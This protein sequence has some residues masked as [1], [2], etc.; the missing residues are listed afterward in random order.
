MA[1]ITL[2]ALLLVCACTSTSTVGGMRA[3][4]ADEWS[5]P[6]DSI[7]VT[8]EGQNVFRVSGCGR[9]ALYECSGGSG[10]APGGSSQSN[11]GS[12]EEYRYQGAGDGCY[13][14]SRD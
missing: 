9:T 2:L 5:C 6:E 4:A 14:A 11:P 1:Q 3:R 8:N 12:A 10:P 13:K 7:G